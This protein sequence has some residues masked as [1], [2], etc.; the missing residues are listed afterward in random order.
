[1]NF[2][3]PTL[4]NYVSVQRKCL[5]SGPVEIGSLSEKDF[6]KWFLQYTKALRK[7]YEK[8]RAAYLERVA[9]K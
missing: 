6:D 7:H 4:I 3:T 5:P 9:T 1:M 2:I 8:K